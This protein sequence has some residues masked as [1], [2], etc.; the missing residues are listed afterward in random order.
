LW[1]GRDD[2]GGVVASGTYF[3][4]LEADAQRATGKMVKSE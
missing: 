2:W 1:D 3:Y 4:R